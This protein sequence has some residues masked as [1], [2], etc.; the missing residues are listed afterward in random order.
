MDVAITI[1][2]GCAGLRLASVIDTDALPSATAET[3][4]DALSIC[5]EHVT[6]TDDRARDARTIRIEAE[7]RSTSFQEHRAPDAW[8]VLAQAMTRGRTD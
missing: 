3:V 5:M 7:G 8:R 1:T 4:L 2:G 6:I